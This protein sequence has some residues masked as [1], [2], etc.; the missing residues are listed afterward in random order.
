MPMSFFKFSPLALSQQVL[1]SESYPFVAHQTVI[2]F[3]K[4]VK[5]EV[6]A[7]ANMRVNI[8]QKSNNHWLSYK[9]RLSYDETK[10]LLQVTYRPYKRASNFRGSSSLDV[11]AR[12]PRPEASGGR[13]A[14]NR[15]HG[16]PP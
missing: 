1:L 14:A 11:S 6:T 13:Q 9:N 15:V 4:S 5:F 12:E 3:H 8:H 7:A 10:L 16:A 2:H